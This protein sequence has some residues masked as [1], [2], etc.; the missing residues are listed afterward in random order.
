[1]S[2]APGQVEACDQAL[3]GPVIIGHQGD[4][5]TFTSAD[6]SQNVELVWPHGFRAMLVARQ[7]ELVDSSGLVVGDEG[8]TLSN[9]GGGGND[10]CS[11]GT[12]IYSDQVSGPTADRVSFLNVERR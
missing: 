8:D 6:T 1:M 7:G 10:V 9:L 4:L 12:H 11:I 3:F 5:L 2:P